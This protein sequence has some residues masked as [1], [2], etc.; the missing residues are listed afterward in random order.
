MDDTI[1]IYRATYGTPE[2]VAQLYAAF[3]KAQGAFEPIAKNREVEIPIKDKGNRNIW[4]ISSLAFTYT[5]H[6][7][8]GNNG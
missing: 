6:S 1:L 2:Q 4:L 8:N 5:I 3:A 7:L